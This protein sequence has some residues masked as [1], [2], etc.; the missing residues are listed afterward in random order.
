M[1]HFLLSVGVATAALAS[2]LAIAPATAAEFHLYLKCTGKLSSSAA[3]ATPAKLDLA[4]RD[5][6][7]TALVQNSDVLPV[8]E[9]MKYVAT[10]QA[11][12]MQLRTPVWG[13][14]GAYYNWFSGV[15]FVW[16]P[17]LKK[18]AMTRLSID[19]QTAELE[20]EL[21]NIEGNVLGKLRMKCN[22]TSMD[23]VPA[24]KF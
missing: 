21:L 9:R 15:L 8:G 7:L 10:E 20:G 17:D 6:N 14:R 5:N 18:L 13:T 11:Y 2:P 3:K 24:P 22:P 16:H 4:L 19:R 23:D 1:K 12:T